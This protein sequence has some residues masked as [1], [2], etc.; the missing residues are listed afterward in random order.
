LRLTLKYEPRLGRLA[1]DKYFNVFARSV[2]DKRVKSFETLS[3]GQKFSN[4]DEVQRHFARLGQSVMPGLFNFDP[5]QLV[6]EDDDDDDG[7]D[8]DDEVSVL[9]IVFLRG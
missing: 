2:S 3:R 5:P 6:D 8:D 9:T 4:L 7:A 1:R